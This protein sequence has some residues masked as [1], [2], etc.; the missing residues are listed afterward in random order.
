MENNR[1][2][3]LQLK[4]DLLT[5][6]TSLFQAQS[7]I[8]ELK[9]DLEQARDEVGRRSTRF[10]LVFILALQMNTLQETVHKECTEREQ[11]KD[12][13]I[14]ARQQ[15]LALKKNGE[16][17]LFD[18]RREVSVGFRC[19]QWSCLSLSAFSPGGFRRDRTACERSSPLFSRLQSSPAE[20]LFLRPLGTGNA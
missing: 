13:L 19:S 20:D 12:A 16:K 10:A 3:T 7:L 14:D 11:L 15:L 4:E 8:T 18:G 2:N 17:E 5:K 6:E 1:T 9:K